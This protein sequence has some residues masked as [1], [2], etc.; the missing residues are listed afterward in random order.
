MPAP[1]RRDA[2]AC[3]RRFP[4]APGS[5]VSHY[6]TVAFKNLL[7]EPVINPDLTH[8]VEAP[9]DLTLELFRDIAIRE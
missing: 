6:D 1:T 8:K 9:D 4:L 3:T 7:M 2:L 5:S